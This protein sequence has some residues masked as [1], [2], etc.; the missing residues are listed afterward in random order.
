[1]KFAILIFLTVLAFANAF[2]NPPNCGW[3]PIMRNKRIAGGTS[4]TPNAWGWNVEIT[5]NNGHVCSGVLVDNTFVITTAT[6]MGGST[7]TTGYT[8]YLGLHDRL[9]TTGPTIQSRTIAS[10]AIH[11]LYNSATYANDIALIKMSSPVTINNYVIPACLDTGTGNLYTTGTSVWVSGWGM[12]Q[13]G[14]GLSRYLRQV[15]TAVIADSQC[16][17]TWSFYNSATMICA[18]ANG[19]DACNGD[20]GGPLTVNGVAGGNWWTIGLTGTP[21]T[22]PLSGATFGKG[23]YVKVSQYITW[24]QTNM[25][26]LG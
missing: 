5:K 23:I 21:H 16:S 1:M 19:K 6:C 20:E 8:L 25:A 26:S 10:I 12:T 14:S 24:I 2:I 11:G 22:C 18:G 4:S 15:N 17:S 13:P 3:K 9:T 7:S